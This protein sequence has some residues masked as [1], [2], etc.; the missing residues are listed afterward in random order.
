[1]AVLFSGFEEKP[2]P[3]AILIDTSTL[4]ID[5]AVARA[6]TLVEARRPRD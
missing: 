5:A 3:D 6:A 4:T 2:A 1:M